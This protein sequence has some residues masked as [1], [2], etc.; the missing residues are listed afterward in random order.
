MEPKDPVVRSDETGLSTTSGDARERSPDPPAVSKGVPT[1]RRLWLFALG[2][3]LLAGIISWVI[4]EAGLPFVRPKSRI[5]QTMGGAMDLPSFVDQVAADSKNATVAYGILGA[6][7]GLALGVAG[8]LVLNSPQRG[9]FAGFTGAVLGAIGGAGGAIAFLPIYFRQLDVAQEELGRDLV[10]PLLV[11]CGAW[12]II[13]AASGIA[14]GLGLGEGRRAARAAVGGLI[15]GALGAV[16]YEVVGALVFPHARTTQPIALTWGPRLLAALSV[17]LMIAVMA[18]STIA[19]APP[20]R[21]TERA[22]G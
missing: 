13:G 7:L 4:D 17:S 20:R 16:V 11:H 2:A 6:M 22:T 3:G 5:V 19:Q 14:L 9:A 12:A 10:I 1:V 18:V 21:A 15:G 8:G